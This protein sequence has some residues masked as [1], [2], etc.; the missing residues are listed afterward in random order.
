MWR[1]SALSSALTSPGGLALIVMT[2]ALAPATSAQAEEV[3]G[4]VRVF[5]HLSQAYG[6]SDRG[7]I[8]A[9][10][11]GGTTDAG[12]IAIQLR[13][14]ISPRD[15]AVVQ[16]SH[17]RRAEDIFSPNQDELEIDWAF[18]E[19]RVAESTSVKV[20]RLNVPLGIYNEIRD[21]GTLLPFFNLP[22]S[23]Y[24]GV[25]STAETVDGI[26]LSHTFAARSEWDL[27]VELYYGGWD[28]AQQ[29]V[30]IDAKFGIVNEE[31]RA[32]D[33]TG[34]QLWLNTPFPG[35]RL[36]AGGLTWLLEGPV[37]PP[38]V[39]E[40][41][42]SYHLSLDLTAEPWIVRSEFRHWRFEQDFGG[43]LSLPVSIPGIAQ[44]EGFYVQLGYWATSKIGLF[45]QYERATLDNNLDLLTNVEDFHE[46]RAISLSYRLRPDLVVRAEHHWADTQFPLGESVAPPTIDTQRPEQVR[47]LIV[48][49]SASF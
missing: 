35:L 37:S 17:E 43:F 33:G 48:A 21:V 9:T 20:G 24:T 31:A 6:R 13:W 28:T 5:G 38:G 47:W 41:W 16:L 45:G 8:Q 49:L 4:K 34:V 25:L 14:E 12:N 1:E 27:E 42:E 39:K 30:D 19:R 26:S 46:D 44:R 3:A 2:A 7:T 11:Q 36:G 22:I 10:T 15:T 18:Y 40:R 29:R 32:E 23:F